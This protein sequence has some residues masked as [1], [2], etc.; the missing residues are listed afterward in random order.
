[1]LEDGVKLIPSTLLEERLSNPYLRLESI[2]I[3]NALKV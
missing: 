2:F 1:M 3:L